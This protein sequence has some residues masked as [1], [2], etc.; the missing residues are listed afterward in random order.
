MVLINVKFFIRADKNVEWL[1]L[2]ERYTS[3]VQAEPGNVFFSI[4]RSLEDPQTY[5][6]IEGF[7]DNEAGGEHMKQQHVSDFF[8][9]MPDIVSTRPHII[10]VDTEVVSGFVEMGEITPR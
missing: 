8:A 4:A 1:V 6:C 9:A 10:Y 3:D 7:R 2:A 5:I